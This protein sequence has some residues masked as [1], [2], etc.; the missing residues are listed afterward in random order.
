MIVTESHPS[1]QHQ[2]ALWL[3]FASLL[4]GMRQAKGNRKAIFFIEV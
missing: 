3:P 1:D 2:I 4:V